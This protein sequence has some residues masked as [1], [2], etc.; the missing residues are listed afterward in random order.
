MPFGNLYRKRMDRYYKFPYSKAF[1][2]S[3][4]SLLIS[5]FQIGDSILFN[6]AAKFGMTLGLKWNPGELDERH[7]FSY[8]LS[9]NDV[10]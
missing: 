8:C 5:E 9:P 4:I 3:S 10:F 1:I 6:D 2:A 7:S